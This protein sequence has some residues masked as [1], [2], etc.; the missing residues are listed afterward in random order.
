MI[1]LGS[2]HVNFGIMSCYFWDHDVILGIWSCY[3]W[4][5]DMLFLGSC[6]AIYGI[7]SCYFADHVMLFLGSCHVIFRIVFCFS[8]DHFMLFLESYHAFLGFM[9]FSFIFD[10]PIICKGIKYI[11]QS[12][13]ALGVYIYI[14]HNRVYIPRDLVSSSLIGRMKDNEP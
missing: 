14:C 7:M 9:L 5:Y 6:H 4:D 11:D 13:T 12:A 8:W 10:H 2:C 1:F 3:F